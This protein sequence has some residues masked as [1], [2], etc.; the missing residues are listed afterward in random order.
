ME[1]SMDA[2]NSPWHNRWVLVTGCTGFLGGAVTREL[3]SSGAR[4]IGL[5]RDRTRAAEFAREVAAGQ[6]KIIHGRVEDAARLHSA[7]VVHE[8][9]AVFHLTDC[10]RGL[11]SALRAAGMYHS[12]VPVIAALPAFRL[13]VTSSDSIA[14][15]SLGIARFG[16]LFGP[17]DRSLT[18]SVPQSVLALLA[19]ERLKPSNGPARDFVFVRDAARACRMLAEAVHDRGH[20]L[21]CTF[22]SGWEFADSALAETVSQILAGHLPENRATEP[23]NPLGW[24]PETSLPDALRE[25]IEWYKQLTRL[26]QSQAAPVIRKAA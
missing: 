11:E 5:V 17:R 18:R 7:M 26:N 15:L 19:D 8:V 2:A 6:V 24:R 3:L 4:V 13:R 21:D 25:T 9:S 10:D 1:A 22:R 14:S 16:E 20:A 12:R 23:I